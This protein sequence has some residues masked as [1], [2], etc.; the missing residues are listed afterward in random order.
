MTYSA[1]TLYKRLKSNPRQ[2]RRS[3][4]ELKDIA[5]EELRKQGLSRH[6][7]VK[8]ANPYGA[9]RARAQYVR[10]GNIIKLH[11]INRFCYKDD[12]RRTM[13]HEITRYRDEQRGTRRAKEF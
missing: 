8:V 10:K 6:I 9:P 5:L 1:D 13:K 4:A 3:K 2:P 12:I 11:P 7:R